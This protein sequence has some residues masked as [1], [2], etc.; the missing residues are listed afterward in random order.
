MFVCL[1]VCLSPAA[2]TAAGEWWRGLIVSATLTCKSQVDKTVNA[3]CLLFP[4]QVPSYYNVVFDDFYQCRD[5][6]HVC[7]RQHYHSR[8][9]RHPPPLPSPSLLLSLLAP[10]SLH[11]LKTLPLL[12]PPSFRRI[13]LKSSWGSGVA[14]RAPP[15]R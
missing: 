2:R 15:V 8:L 1:F 3:F 7:Q 5:A 9:L 12:S 10:C 6:G 13:L 4:I 14:P 11:A